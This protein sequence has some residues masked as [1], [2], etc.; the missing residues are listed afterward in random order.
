MEELFSNENIK[1]S[2]LGIQQ[3]FIDVIGI[4]SAVLNVDI[5][6][7]LEV[8]V[9]NYHLYGAIVHILDDYY[10]LENLHLINAVAVKNRIVDTVLIEEV[11]SQ[12]Y[13]NST[14]KCF[15]NV[16]NVR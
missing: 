9:H 2:S 12:Q 1:N 16:S 11:I 3:I 5:S 8:F 13:D 4:E 14:A 7:C 15:A 6:L 10:T